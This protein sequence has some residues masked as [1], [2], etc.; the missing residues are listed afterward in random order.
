MEPVVEQKPPLHPQHKLHVTALRLTDA[1]MFPIPDC[2][3]A[4]V[5]TWTNCPDCSNHQQK[6][7][8]RNIKSIQHSRVAHPRHL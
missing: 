7:F 6:A 8:F 3:T 5:L 4:L 1:E 2:T